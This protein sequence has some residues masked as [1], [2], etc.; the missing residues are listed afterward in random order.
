MN[1]L[2]VLSTVLISV[3]FNSSS[4]SLCSRPV[5]QFPT[6]PLREPITAFSNLLSQKPENVSVDQ[7][8][9]K[10]IILGQKWSIPS[11]LQNTK[12]WHFYIVRSMHYDILKL[13][14]L[15]NA[16]FYNLYI[17]SLLPISYMFRQSCRLQAAHA[18]ISLKHTAVNSLQETYT[19]LLVCLL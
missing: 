7:Y 14:T 17:F 1:W 16:Q 8:T 4:V 6:A 12:I 3:T 19:C 10:Y 11:Q 5:I 15:I 18:K 13:A 9:N 2:L